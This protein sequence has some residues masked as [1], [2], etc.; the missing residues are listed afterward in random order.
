MQHLQPRLGYRDRV[1][2]ISC[3]VGRCIV[4]N[5]DIRIGT[6]EPQSLQQNAE[7]LP[8]VIGGHYDQHPFLGRL[9]LRT[10]LTAG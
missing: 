4:D 5:Q 7:V 3:A 6:M 8:L 1:G 9:L 2:K 10:V